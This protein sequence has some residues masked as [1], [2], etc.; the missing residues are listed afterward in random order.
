MSGD[1]FLGLVTVSVLYADSKAKENLEKELQSVY[2][3]IL[4][5]SDEVDFTFTKFYDKEFGQG[6]KRY[7]LSFKK[8]CNPV[9]YYK[10]KLVCIDIENKYK[11]NDK[12]SFNL[13]VGFVELCKFVLL[14]TKPSTYRIFLREGVYAQSNYYFKENS[15]LVW[16]YTYPDYKTEFAI[17]FFNR[18]R[19]YVKSI[20]K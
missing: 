9:D 7:F 15:F 12:R 19:D 18:V 10:E 3:A 4:H 13:D 17:C 2:G 16:P 1:V 20:D 8:L 5:R 6:I 14:S 11:N